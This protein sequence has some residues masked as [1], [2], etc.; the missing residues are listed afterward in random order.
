MDDKKFSHTESEG[1]APPLQP[2]LASLMM[3]VACVTLFAACSRADTTQ[4]S[5]QTSTFTLTEVLRLGDEEAGDTVLFSAIDYLSVNSRGEMVVTER[6]RAEISTFGP[7]GAFLGQVGARGQGPGEYRFISSA[8]V[9]PADS[10]YV[11]EVLLDRLLIY[12]P[13]NFLFV[14]DALLENDGL[15][16]VNGFV[17]AVEDN[18]LITLSLSPF[19]RSE[20]GSMSINDDTGYEVRRANLDGSIEPEAVAR[21]RSF[22]MIYS[23]GEGG[24]NFVEVPFGRHTSYRMGPNNLLY[25]G[26]NDSIRIAVTAPDGSVNATISYDP[27]PVPISDTEMTEAA[28]RENELFQELVDARDPYKAKPAF[29]T[30]VVDEVS[31]V[32][33]KLSSLEGATEADWLI[34]DHRSNVVG[35][36]S[37]PLAVNLRIIRQ[38]RAYGSEQQDGADPMVLVYEINE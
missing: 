22:D 10:I 21:M 5:A 7:D 3:A 13:E 17:G 37:L 30:F 6:R 29:Q 12:D 33:V 27:P 1:A 18:W 8:I 23:I 36:A 34:L 35:T 19:L 31:R 11:L 28:H 2:T 38:D 26:W 24:M 9:G 32:W 16:S 15:K 25:H 14:R 4:E 20:D